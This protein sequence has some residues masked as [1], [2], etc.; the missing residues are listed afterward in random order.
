METIK[1]IGFG[2]HL[3]KNSLFKTISERKIEICWVK[4]YKR[5]FNIR[6][7]KFKSVKE[8]GDM[9]KTAILN[10]QPKENAE[11]NAIVF[12]A[13]QDEFE[14]L[15][16]RNKSYYVKEVPF[17]DYKTKEESG[18]AV[19]F[20]GKKMRHGERAVEDDILPLPKYFERVRDAAY[21]I[22]K[23]FG[24]EF[25]KTTFVGDGRVV[26]EYLEK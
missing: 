23:K 4:G 7:S 5:I 12:D 14:R 26:K 16:I 2:G 17:Y 11:A 22:S 18:K 9:I 8:G 24:K 21:N 13:N 1:I 20:I 10:M 3:D 15:K 6:A 19:L 25:D